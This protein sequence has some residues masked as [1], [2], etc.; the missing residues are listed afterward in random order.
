[1]SVDARQEAFARV[2]GRFDARVLEPSPPAVTV[3]PW[4]ADDPVAPEPHRTG[5][6]LLGPVSSADRTWDDL[7]R[8][9]PDLSDWCAARWLGAY[10]RLGPLPDQAVRVATGNALHAVAEHV[11]AP[12]RRRATGKIG[13]RFTVGGFGTPFFG[14][15]EQVR[16]EGADLVVVRAGREARTPITT[17]D[18]AGRFVGIEPGAPADLY[19]PAT[20]VDPDTP[21]AVDPEAARFLG[22]WYGFSCSVLEE[23]RVVA[24]ATDTRT[25]LWPEHFDLSIDVGDEA[26][27]TR[28]TLGASPGDAAHPEP[29]LY[30]TH[31]SAD[32]KPD[33]FWNDTAF[34]GANLPYAG[35]VDAEDQRATAIDFFLRALAALGLSDG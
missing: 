13:L 30:A 10:P 8:E 3:P 12:A 14:S 21:L 33:P 27:G 6:P 29:Y 20:A 16:V 23:M 9:Q 17:I 25:Q 1:V 19:E 11:L 26:A 18:A 5:L 31:W 28:G 22:D 7:T 15:N 34:A 32:V 2:G 4:F 35:L 24:G